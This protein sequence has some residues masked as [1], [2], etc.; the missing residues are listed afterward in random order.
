VH[1]EEEE[2]AL[3]IASLKPVKHA[4]QTNFTRLVQSYWPLV[5]RRESTFSVRVLGYLMETSY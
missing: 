3:E 4:V 2:A 5:A 1:K